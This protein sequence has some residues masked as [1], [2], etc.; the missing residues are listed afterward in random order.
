MWKELFSRTVSNAE[1]GFARQAVASPGGVKGLGA[2]EGA[3]RGDLGSESG[4]D[5]LGGVIRRRTDWVII[6]VMIV[7]FAFATWVGKG[8][9]ENTAGVSV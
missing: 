1:P 7:V 4:G 5:S 8:R 3:R 9:A 6:I 2:G